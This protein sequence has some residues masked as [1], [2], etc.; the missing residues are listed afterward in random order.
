M[1]NVYDVPCLLLLFSQTLS[2]SDSISIK[3]S[4]VCRLGFL[5]LHV[6]PDSSK[7]KTPGD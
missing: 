1:I 4:Y 7:G 2:S 5:L 3:V 6:F